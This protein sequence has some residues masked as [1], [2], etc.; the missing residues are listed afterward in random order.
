MTSTFGASHLEVMSFAAAIAVSAMLGQEGQ[1]PWRLPIGPKGERTIAVGKLMH[2]VSG[3]EAS[4]DD[5]VTSAKGFRYVL[6]GESH[7]HAGHHQMQADIIEA[8]AKSGRDV[9]VGFEMFT[10]PV[11]K[12][13]NPWTLGWQTEEE[14]I[15]QSD[16]KKQWG[17]DFA[18]YR[19]IFNVTKKY[20][21][22]MIALNVPRDWVRAV[23]RGGPGALTAEQKTQMPELYLQNAEH[24]SIFNAM[25]GGHPPTG[26]QGENIY[27]AQVL[28]DEGMADSAIKYLKQYPT[29]SNTIVV[30]VAGSGHVAYGQGIAYRISRQTQ[31]KSLIV[32]LTSGK[33]SSTVSRG[34]GDFVYCAP[35][36]ATSNP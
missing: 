35:E 12:Q 26:P 25:M 18:L 4:L 34:L 3:K 9:L 14:F 7:D 8:L 13:L 17:F 27:A 5:I 16:W 24:R 19:P 22:P 32:M 21:L 6:I 10:R 23:G 31:E 33:E 11:Q 28:W 20:K 2:M 1:D 29:T 15:V 36:K 30:I